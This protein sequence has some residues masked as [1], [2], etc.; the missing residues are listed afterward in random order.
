MRR[1]R[2]A[3][4]VIGAL[5]VAGGSPVIAEGPGGTPL[6]SGQRFEFP[7]HGIAVTMPAGWLN[8]WQPPSLPIFESVIAAAPIDGPGECAL[9][10]FAFEGA[11]P[12]KIAETLGRVGGYDEFEIS[13]GL[14]LPAGDAV[15][16]EPV[17]RMSAH[18][19]R[20]G[21]PGTSVAYVLVAPHGYAWLWCSTTGAPLS[22]D[23]LSIAETFEFLPVEE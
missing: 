10:T 14:A 8:I 7:E 16:E 5:G 12:S 23:W 6:P 2:S 21:Q 15:P 3:L 17:V 19:A 11:E 1:A 20:G 13:E 9:E 18:E 22:D 4:V